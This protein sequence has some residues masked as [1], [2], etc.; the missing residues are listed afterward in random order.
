MK[1]IDLALMELI[2]GIRYRMN[3]VIK[4][5]CQIMAQT[6]SLDDCLKDG[7]AAM[8]QWCFVEK[9]GFVRILEGCCFW[10]KL[11]ETNGKRT[12]QL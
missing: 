8:S 5:K 4:G 10:N 12:I 6:V 1:A 2:V 3:D 9:M 11:K 7:E